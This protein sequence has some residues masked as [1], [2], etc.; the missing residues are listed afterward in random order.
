MKLRKVVLLVVSL[1]VVAA[2]VPGHARA[3]ASVYGAFSSSLL[4]DPVQTHVL[5]GGTVG[6]LVG[7]PTIFGR[8]RVDADLQAR[9][10]SGSGETLDSGMVGPRFTLPLKRHKLAPYAE[11][12]VGFGRYTSQSTNPSL[13]APTG[14]SDGLLQF[15]GGVSR[16]L[17]AH[18]EAVLDYSYAQF[19]ALGGIY[20]PKSASIGAVYHFAGR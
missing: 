1:A 17:S 13:S 2:A 3:Q 9:F 19:Y 18:L 14:T 8:V 10:V 4:T 15:S 16:Q 6:V 11:V 5:Y 20:N 7:G 12:M